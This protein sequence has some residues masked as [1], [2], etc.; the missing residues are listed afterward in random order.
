[1]SQHR[2][3]VGGMN[4]YSIISAEEFD[5]KENQIAFWFEVYGPDGGWLSSFQSNEA[6]AGF[7]A[8]DQE[9]PHHPRPR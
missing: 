8:L 6:A 3:I 2:K 9:K 7:I 5:A 4:G 1:M